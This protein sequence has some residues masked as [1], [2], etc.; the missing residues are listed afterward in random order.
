MKLVI[1]DSD[2]NDVIAVAN[3]FVGLKLTPFQARTILENNAN[4]A[5]QILD[6]GAFDTEVRSL[7]ANIFAKQ[8]VGRRW[9]TYGEGDAVSEKFQKDFE[10]AAT[11]AGFEVVKCS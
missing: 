9:P 8:L 4:Y 3:D 11:K 7:L 6:Y 10:A 2:I 5:S 1:E